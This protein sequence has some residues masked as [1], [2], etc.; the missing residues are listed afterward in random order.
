MLVGIINGHPLDTA[1]RIMWWWFV[2]SVSFLHV[3]MSCQSCCLF[4]LLLSLMIQSP[5]ENIQMISSP[6]AWVVTVFVALAF[7]FFQS[8]SSQPGGGHQ[9]ESINHYLTGQKIFGTARIKMVR[10]YQKTKGS[11]RTGSPSTVK[12]GVKAVF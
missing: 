10:V 6:N 2:S 3:A 7:I 12:V 11:A 8:K 5:N 4:S 9:L 1:V